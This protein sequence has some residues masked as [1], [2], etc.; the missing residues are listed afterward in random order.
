MVTAKRIVVFGANGQL[1]R[2]LAALLGDRVIALTRADADLAQ[3][4]SLEGILTAHQP[5]VVV[6]AAA[7]TAVDKAEEEQALAHR[8]NAESPAVIA[9]WCAANHVPLVHYSTDY[10]FNGEGEKPWRETDTTAPLN[11]YGAS[12][13]AGEQAVAESGADYLIFRSSWLY[14]AQGSN[15][16]NTMLRLA[17]EREQL[18]VVADQ[19]GAPCYVP[20]LAKASLD[21]LEKSMAMEAFPSGIYHLT[22]T[23]FTSWH[24]FAEAIFDMARKNGA[25]LCVKTVEPIPSSA[26]PTPAKRPHNSRLSCSRIHT[27]FGIVLPKW[28]QGLAQAAEEKYRASHHLPD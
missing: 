1:G 14:D 5:E 2:A 12:K 28:E 18:R 3:P 25:E 26:Y 22:H 11:A 20:Q 4:E 6:N 24:G 10:V 7:Y 19:T 13:L 15:F 23:G 9:R 8:I 16:F 21:A 17:A 27:V